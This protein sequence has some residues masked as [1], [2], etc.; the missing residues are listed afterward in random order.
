MTP[1]EE[2]RSC[3]FVY[4]V[5]TSEPKTTTLGYHFSMS[6]ELLGGQQEKKAE[7]VAPFDSHLELRKVLFKSK[8]ERP[9]ALAEWK[10]KYHRQKEGLM[11][12]Y[13]D[14]VSTIRADPHVPLSELEAKLTDAG[15][16][17]GMSSTQKNTSLELLKGFEKHRN[18]LDALEK[19]YSDPREFFKAVTGE[20][21]VG[22]IVVERLPVSFAITAS[23]RRDLGRLYRDH[24][25]TGPVTLAQM[26]KSALAYGFMLP[27]TYTEELNG[28]VLVISSAITDR[29]PFISKSS[30]S[31]KQHE[32]QHVL[33]H[34][35][36][37]ILDV[38]SSA[39]TDE[40]LADITTPAWH[41]K[42]AA[43]KEYIARSVRNNVDVVVSKHNK[44]GDRV[45]MSLA[46][47]DMLYRE[48]TRVIEKPLR[49]E[50]LAQFAGGASKT[51]ILGEVFWPRILG[52]SYRFDRGAISVAQQFT[53]RALSA[54]ENA[55]VQA[56]VTLRLKQLFRN[57]ALNGTSAMFTL[58]K[59][60][61]TDDEI[62]AALMTKQVSQWKRLTERM[63]AQKASFK[64]G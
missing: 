21:P 45:G 46:I 34:F 18:Q 11:R 50:L 64:T 56:T 54:T 4:I 41:G 5:G 49:D 1:S 59:L 10:E 37:P 7:T 58:R 31:T 35:F 15:N 2:A 43:A 48:L 6:K 25:Q 26:G 61:Y 13:G 27:R 39:L 44:S 30:S 3:F 14:I 53:S 55:A 62:I 19:K 51:D 23:S 60:G 29:I 22:K 36:R 28:K 32:E 52:G 33:E 20:Y 8:T 47:A 42:A 40:F 9:A 63:R 57:V 24:T 38:K 17:F 16:N 12:I